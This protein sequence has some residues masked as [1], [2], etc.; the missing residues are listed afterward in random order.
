[1]V[2]ARRT[3]LI[4][5]TRRLFSRSTIAP[6][7]ALNGSAGNVKA[8][9][10]IPAMTTEWVTLLTMTMM[11]KF[12]ALRIVSEISCASHNSTKLRF[13]STC[14]KLA[15]PGDGSEDGLDRSEEH[16]SELQSPVVISYAVFC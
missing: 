14:R 9:M 5:N 11:P 12:A 2:P 1:M 6:A 16:T 13:F 10:A 15:I 7:T 4:H 8:M 3:L